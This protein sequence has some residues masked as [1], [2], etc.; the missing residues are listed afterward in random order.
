MVDHGD[1][2]PAPSNVRS[3]PL[4]GRQRA[5]PESESD[6]GATILKY[7]RVGLRYK[8]SI[9]S[10]AVVGFIAGAL[11]SATAVPIYEA[12]ATVAIGPDSSNVVP[13]QN[14]NLYYAESWRYYQTQYELIHS[15]AVAERVVDK[16]GLVTRK[17]LNKPLK[18]TPSL[19]D[20]AEKA[21]GLNTAAKPKDTDTQLALEMQ[22]PGQLT[23]RREA[24]ANM[25]RSGVSVDG[26]D[27]SQIARVRFD[28]PNPQ[29]AA[30]V[31]NAIVDAYIELG[32]EARLDRTKRTSAWLTERL[33]D[34]R[35]KVA[36]AED[37]LQA[38][39][40]SSGLLDSQ[41]M[42]QISADKLKFLNDEVIRTQ[43]A[44]S[45]LSERYGPKHPRMI[46][47]KAELA[48]ARQRLE[49]ASKKIVDDKN[50]QFELSKLEREVA[51]DRQLYQAF[52]SKFQETNLSSQYNLTN[53]QIVDKARVPKSPIRPD[54]NK[55][56]FQWSMMGLFVGILLALFREQLHNTYRTNEDIEQKLALPV[57]GVVPLLGKKGKRVDQARRRKML[58]KA[59]EGPAPERYF[60]EDSKSAFSESINHVRTG[61]A[62]SD[63]DN[64]PQTILITSS[65]QGEG[66][67]TLASNLALSFANLGRT[68]LIDADL[69][70]PRV[71]YLTTASSKGGLVEYVAGLRSLQECVVQDPECPSLYILKGGVVPPNPLELLSSQTLAKTL[72]ELRS[73][74]SHIIIDT[75]P[76]L[77]VSDAIVLGHI[78]D[79]LLLVVQ[80]ERT[81]TKM[82]RD[83]LKRLGNAGIRTMG[84]V[85]TQVQV[86]RSAYYYDGKYQYYYG[87]YYRSADDPAA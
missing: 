4:E 31:T 3:L 5:A 34:L 17:D 48:S 85:L 67:T 50:K 72:V 81:T 39:Q 71:E 19:I 28:S 60:L 18:A 80:A 58:R 61:I 22:S 35:K 30:E 27:Q 64:P 74:F 40:K 63:V 55:F 83:A 65:V 13:G 52:L 53:A 42:D 32:L 41:S 54:K 59:E 49:E 33:G 11:Q 6:T 20:L 9:L 62:Y 87:G 26:S 79:A 47:A 75:A 70:K 51:S 37:K 84:V 82:T 10:F 25:I 8:W 7:L 69:R 78:T 44:V 16:L 36:N 12:E 77:P 29:F 15:R 56:V 86:R 38:F 68:L 14:L 73:K 76:I 66:K 43:K 21:L 57:L 24:L 45:E 46:N 2:S 1:R 23:K